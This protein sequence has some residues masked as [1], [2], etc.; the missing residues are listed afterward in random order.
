MVDVLQ[1]ARNW[2]DNMQSDA[3][4]PKPRD[5]MEMYSAV[6]NLA[7]EYADARQLGD[8]QTPLPSLD[9]AIPLIL[10]TRLGLPRT[11]HLLQPLSAPDCAGALDLLL[12]PCVVFRP[13]PRELKL[14]F[15]AGMRQQRQLPDE[16]IHRILRFA[17]H[18]LEI[19]LHGAQVGR[20]SSLCTLERWIFACRSMALACSTSSWPSSRRRRRLGST[21]ICRPFACRKER[22]RWCS[23]VQASRRPQLC[24]PW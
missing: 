20:R 19:Q 4:G 6:Y 16:I 11:E 18:R 1:V 21:S 5:K 24:V 17:A 2:D 3:P 22:R 7:P 15:V 23:R 13:L 9:Y 10:L 14:T 12:P 8:S